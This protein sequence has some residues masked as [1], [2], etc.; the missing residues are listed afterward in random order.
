M[1]ALLAGWMG[2]PMAACGDDRCLVAP[3]ARQTIIFFFLLPLRRDE[4][5]IGH[6]GERLGEPGAVPG[7]RA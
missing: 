2:G 6:V 7:V 1:I 5:R 3:L 4:C